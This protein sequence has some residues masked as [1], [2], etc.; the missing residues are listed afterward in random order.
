MSDGM[1]D[2]LAD[3][4]VGNDGVS[5]SDVSTDGT[6]GA[7]SDDFFINFGIRIQEVFISADFVRIIIVIVAMYNGTIASI[8]IPNTNPP[9]PC[10]SARNR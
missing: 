2:G 7:V 4:G 6:I 10:N 8:I 1:S 5:D 9:K 3:G